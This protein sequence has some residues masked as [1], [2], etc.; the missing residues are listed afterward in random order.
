[1]AFG[2]WHLAVGIWQL[3]FGSWHLAVGSWHLAFGIWH[4]AVGGLFLR[5]TE[6]RVLEAVP[7]SLNVALA[8]ADDADEVVGEFGVHPWNFVFGHVTG[9]AIVG[10]HTADLRGMAGLVTA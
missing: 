8:F 7:G 4:L 3:A 10:A 9:D 5:S 1:L 2:S 6:A